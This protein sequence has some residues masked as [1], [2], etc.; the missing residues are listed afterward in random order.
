MADVFNLCNFIRMQIKDIQLRQILQISNPL[1]V[2][3]AQHEHSESRHRMQVRD[4]LD[5]IVVEIQENK[6]WQTYQIFNFLNMIVLQIEKTKPLLA[7]KQRHMRQVSLVQVEPVRI[8][9]PL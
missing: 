5:V 9:I 8:G 1:D 3:F 4:F 7:L 2:V 6:C